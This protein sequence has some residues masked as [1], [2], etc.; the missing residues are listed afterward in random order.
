MNT[1]GLAAGL[2]VLATPIG[3]LADLTLRALEV[4]RA[5]DRIAAEDTRVTGHLLTHY[6]VQKPLQ[7]VREHNEA[8]AAASICAQIAAGEAVVYVSDAGTPGISDPGARLARAVW[9]AG[10]RVVPIPGPAA[11]TAALSASGFEAAHWL[12]YGFLPAKGVAR[13]K[14]LADLHAQPWAL[15]F[16]EAPHRIREMLAD[17]HAVFGDARLVFIG[18]ELTKQFEDL[19]RLPLGETAAWLDAHSHRERGEFVLV[20]EAPAALPQAPA[21]AARILHLLAEELPAS[22]AARLAAKITGVKRADLYALTQT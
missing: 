13:R 14:V 22:Q 4:L 10:L 3:H 2:Y 19:A 15:V 11:V 20:V 12:F 18:R 9:Q 21:E 16:Y 7:S 17:L 1:T 6:G 5:A 8:Q